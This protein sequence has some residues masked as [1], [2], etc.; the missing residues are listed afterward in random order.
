M[1]EKEESKD[2]KEEEVGEDAKGGESIY[3]GLSVG[4]IKKLKA[5]I[6]RDN[7]K[8]CN[9]NKRKNQNKKKK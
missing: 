2:K 7:K 6:F 9:Q 8:R 5:K 3:K 1:T 4:Q